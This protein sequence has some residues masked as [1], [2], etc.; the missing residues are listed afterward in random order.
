MDEKSNGSYHIANISE[1]EK[2][3]LKETELKF[4]QKTGKDFYIIVW[5]KD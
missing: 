3:L 1:E 4:K 5:E 2:A